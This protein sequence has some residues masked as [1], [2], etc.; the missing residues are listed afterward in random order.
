MT[1]TLQ[2]KP[3]KPLRKR[4]VPMKTRTAV[5]SSPKNLKADIENTLKANISTTTAPNE[6]ILVDTHTATNMDAEFTAAVSATVQDPVFSPTSQAFD[7][8]PQ[9]KTPEFVLMFQQQLRAYSQ[10]LE[11]VEK[12][13]ATI[14]RLQRELN[15]SQAALAA[16][17]AEV[18]ALKS[19]L[20]AATGPTVTAFAPSPAGSA[21][22]KYADEYPALEVGVSPVSGPSGSLGSGP[23]SS[24]P[25]GVSWS[26]VTKS[27]GKVN[28]KKVKAS[29]RSRDAAAR[30]FTP[31]SESQGFNSSDA[32][33]CPDID[34]LAE[35][36]CDSISS[37]LDNSVGRSKP[38]LS[39]QSWFWTSLLQDRADFREDCRRVWKNEPDA[40]RKAV[41]WDKYA[42]A[43][44]Q[45]K[46]DL[47]NGDFAETTDIIKR[48]R[49]N[50]VT[51]PRYSHVDG[52][53][54]A[55]L[56]MSQHLQTVFSGSTLP[57]VRQPVPPK[58]TG[59]HPFVFPGDTEAKHECPINEDNA[60]VH[61]L[62]FKMVCRIKHL[63]ADTL[64][65]VIT[66]E[67]TRRTFLWPK[68]QDS[69]VLWSSLSPRLKAILTE[70]VDPGIVDSQVKKRRQEILDSIRAG[71]DPPVLL[72]ACRP[73]LGI[74]PILY[75]PM[76]LYERSRLVRWRMGW[77]PA[78]PVGC[79]KCAHTHASRRHL[80]A[81][82]SV[83]TRL[84]VSETALPNPLDYFLN[85]YLP[86]QKP[87][88]ASS[89][90]MNP[91]QKH[92]V[93]YWP[94]LCAIML[95]IDMICHP[96]QEFSSAALD[97][98]GYSLLL[99]WYPV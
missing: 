44:A 70:C 60:R 35:E 78:R 98:T 96:D 59:P 53:A 36:L 47:S 45:F 26:G 55:A 99:E 94:V 20:A 72:S 50:R 56:S 27:G 33:V 85:T 95:E 87:I 3:E 61:T 81:C 88:I 57:D 42:E 16:T 15:A 52:P 69:C 25:G 6:I 40:L 67:C 90:Y 23:G 51:T 37:S 65:S 62:V 24:A 91:K 1:S 41:L 11:H 73:K 84:G 64:I 48:I 39:G 74:D 30:M 21:A 5:A 76:S 8:T 32:L 9:P 13:H 75:L 12:T 7:F 89:I 80:I 86:T 28:K 14:E 19:A 2:A 43:D 46:L 31:V 38:V 66:R 79:N 83:A 10:R 92:L 68:L 4:S 17:R 77:L 54:A 49:R 29:P 22:S 97:D 34:A 82:L 71:P 63:P 58:P 18:D 93:K